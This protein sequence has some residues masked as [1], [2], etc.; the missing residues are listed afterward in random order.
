MQWTKEKV[1]EVIIECRNAGQEAAKAKL[2]ELSGQG[3]KFAVTDR[4]KLVGTMLDVCGFAHLSISARGKFYLLAKK[5]SKD[6]SLR[7]HC[8]HDSYNGGGW[9][10]IYDMTMRQEMSINVA[11]YR[12]VNSVLASYEITS[13]V[14]SRID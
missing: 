9:F 5:L 8:D 4:E 13:N 14:K 3:P 11:A 6:L 7:F 10:S 2:Q 1:K 12:A